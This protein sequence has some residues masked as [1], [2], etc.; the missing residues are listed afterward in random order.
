M[1]DTAAIT[2]TTA[3]SDMSAMLTDCNSKDCRGVKGAGTMVCYKMGI[4][5][6]S[7]ER[8]RIDKLRKT[9]ARV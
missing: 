5:C 1:K 8:K 9:E 7:E 4:V 6:S 2:T 3:I